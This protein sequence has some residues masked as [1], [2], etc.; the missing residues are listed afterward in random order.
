MPKRNLIWGLLMGLVGVINVGNILTS[1]SSR[2]W[3]L[4]VAYSL[5]GAVI[6]W[7]SVDYLLEFNEDRLDY[8]DLMS[9]EFPV[10][11]DEGE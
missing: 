2:E 1:I 7:G 3:L 11:A 10:V 6:L 5:V 4:V 8:K 9:V